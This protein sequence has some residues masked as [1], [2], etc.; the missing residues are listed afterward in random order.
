[1][2]HELSA[3]K[4]GHPRT[5]MEQE[6]GIGVSFAYVTSKTT[7]KKYKS[8]KVIAWSGA[9]PG[10]QVRGE[11]ALKKIAP[12]GG[13]RENCWGISCEKSRFY[14]KKS[15]FSNFRVRLGSAPDDEFLVGFVLLDL[16]LLCSVLYIVVCTFLLAIV[17]PVLRITTSDYH[18]G[19][20]KTFLS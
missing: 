8:C 2:R 10:I 13:R 19:I 1:M 18:F 6:L 3:E 20:F 15:Y 4:L 9:D 17:L 7:K 14:A 12:S 11:G 16:C 5:L